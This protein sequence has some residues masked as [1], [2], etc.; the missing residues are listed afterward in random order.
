MFISLETKN[1]GFFQF[2]LSN[3]LSVL[4]RTE[5]VALKAYFCITTKTK[6]KTQQ[7][8]YHVSLVWLLIKFQ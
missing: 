7:T 4:E 1:M 6:T 2:S 5:I 8:M 3:G